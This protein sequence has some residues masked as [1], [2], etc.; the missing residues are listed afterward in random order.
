MPDRPTLEELKD[1]ART[2]RTAAFTYDF[3]GAIDAHD[4]QASLIE[5]KRNLA[6]FAHWKYGE[7]ARDTVTDA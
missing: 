3:P 4:P 5:A 6:A 1:A 7:A 2:L